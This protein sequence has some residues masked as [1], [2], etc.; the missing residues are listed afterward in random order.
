MRIVKKQSKIFISKYQSEYPYTRISCLTFREVVNKNVLLPMSDMSNSH[1][2]KSTVDGL[3]ARNIKSI[4]VIVF[5]KSFHSINLSSPQWLDLLLLYT[6]DR[7]GRLIYSTEFFFTKTW[8]R[9]KVFSPSH[10][11]EN[12]NIEWIW[13]KVISYLFF[14]VLVCNERLENLL[15]AI[16]DFKLFPVA[17]LLI[18]QKLFL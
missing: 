10:C 13:F 3:V 8:F 18:K 6:V 1:D 15:S 5:K 9:F 16:V 2:L 4:I 11:H 7:W 12:I 14:C 17:L